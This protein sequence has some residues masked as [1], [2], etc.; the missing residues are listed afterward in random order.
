MSRFM[1][2]AV[3]FF[4]ANLTALSQAAAAGPAEGGPQATLSWRL[5]FG[6][7]RFQPGYALAVGYR[8]ADPRQP[9]TELFAVD[10]SDR[11][12]LAR[13]AG[14]PLLDRR[15]RTDQTEGEAQPAATATPWYTRQWVLWTVGGLAATVALTGGD[16]SVEYN[17]NSSNTS[18][19]EGDCLFTEDGSTVGNCNG[20]VVG[21]NDE[22]EPCAVDG[23]GNDVP[24]ACVP[25]GGFVGSDARGPLALRRHT[26]SLDAG[27]GGMGDLFVR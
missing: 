13:L 25:T 9:A 23:F 10:V 5:E 11:A 1:W 24:D 6:S 27:T 14:V 2:S 4:V 3:F 7:G 22:G 21:T 8:T 15:Y 18:R 16:G 19:S 20:T 26:S 17:D 12:A